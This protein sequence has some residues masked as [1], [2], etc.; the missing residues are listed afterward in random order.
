ML[1]SFGKMGHEAEDEVA[2]L[3]TELLFVLTWRDGLVSVL[4]RLVDSRAAFAINSKLAFSARINSSTHLMS[5]S[6]SPSVL[7]LSPAFLS[8]MRSVSLEFIPAS[9]QLCSWSLSR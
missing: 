3:G 7:F 2:L 9:I 4:A 5:S 6:H 8:Q 1:D